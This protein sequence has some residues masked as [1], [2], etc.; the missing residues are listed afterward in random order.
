[1]FAFFTYR[2]IAGG[3][4]FEM[5][6]HIIFP[7]EAADLE[8]QAKRIVFADN[9][10][11]GDRLIRKIGNLVGG[12]IRAHNRIQTIEKLNG[13]TFIR[14]YLVYV[15]Y[16]LVFGTQMPMLK[17]GKSKIVRSTYVGNIKT[18]GYILSVSLEN[19]STD[20]FFR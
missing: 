4:P 19:F 10:T 11:L 7:A 12:N 3:I 17:G 15:F 8:I 16:K 1:M 20:V 6:V 13:Y 9:K 18:D 2:N 5:S 14:Y